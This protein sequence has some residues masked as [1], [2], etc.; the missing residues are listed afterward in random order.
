M[1]KPR[2]DRNQ[3]PISHTERVPTIYVNLVSLKRRSV[4]QVRLTPFDNARFLK[5]DLT[6]S[7]I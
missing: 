2:L 4:S 7:E 5:F 6:G 1:K 3:I